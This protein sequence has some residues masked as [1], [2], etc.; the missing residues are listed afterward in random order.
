M[1]EVKIIRDGFKCLRCGY[2]WIPKGKR[3]SGKPPISCPKCR[4]KYWNK[5]RVRFRKSQE[6]ELTKRLRKQG[7]SIKKIARE[8]NPR[9]QSV[10]EELKEV[11]EKQKGK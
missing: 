8:L 2:E 9:R 10:H 4:S 6:V 11:R 7:T 5:P 1:S 3:D